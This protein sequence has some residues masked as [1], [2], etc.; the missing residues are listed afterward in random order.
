MIGLYHLVSW[1]CAG[2]HPTV[3]RLMNPVEV[4]DSIGGGVLNPRKRKSCCASSGKPSTRHSIVCKVNDNEPLASSARVTSRSNHLLDPQ[5]HG[6]RHAE[7]F[8][9]Q[10]QKSNQASREIIFHE[11]DDRRNLGAERLLAENGSLSLAMIS[12]S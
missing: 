9:G 8:F 2:S 7:S 11:D 5:R 6:S 1:S 4:K 10:S 3:K 12:S